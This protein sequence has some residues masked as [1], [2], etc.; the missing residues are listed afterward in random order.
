[1]HS[2]TSTIPEKKPGILI[3][4][5]YAWLWLGGTVSSFG[6]ILYDFTL[7]LWITLFL[8]RNQPWAPL[9]VSGVL[10]A[11]LG[12]AFLCGPIVG[13]FVDRANKRRTMLGMDALR[14]VLVALLIP[15]TNTFPLPFVP[16]GRLPLTLPLTLQLTAI[17]VIVV[18]ATLSGQ[19]FNPA[20]TALMADIVPDTY[21]ARAAGLGQAS[22]S[23]A[24][25]LAPALAPVLAITVGVEWAIA[26]NALS[27]VVSFFTILRVHPPALETSSGRE[28][29]QR[30]VEGTALRQFYAGITLVARNRILST[31]VI[32]VALVMLGAATI[33][34]LDIFF[35]LHNLHAQPQLYGL[36][37]TAMG[38]GVLAGSILAASLS[39]RLGLVRVFSLSL[40][41]AGALV[42]AYSRMTSLAPALMLVLVVGIAQ[43]TLNTVVAPL[44]LRVTPRQFVG[45]VSAIVMSTAA[46]AQLVGTIVTGFL[47][48]Q[49]LE[50]FHLELHGLEFGPFDTIIGAGGVIV[51]LG[52]F[53]ALLR[54]GE[55]GGATGTQSSLVTQSSATVS[56]AMPGPTPVG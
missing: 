53:Y 16:A 38:I 7:V 28:A 42:V 45:R 30:V 43:A 23:V 46:L 10:A 47:A 39:E 31:L 9:A 49:I 25:L 8:G 35:A 55:G 21:R 52:A 14:A 41:A 19:F 37:S 56:K 6:D 33:N 13:V 34:T 20:R 54:L 26:A 17:Y 29:D 18:L 36:L 4:R 27:F 32:S 11:S 48:G 24:L 44:M 22:Q 51:V 2:T 5:N 3:N 15:A 1:M 12:T 50:D 40:L